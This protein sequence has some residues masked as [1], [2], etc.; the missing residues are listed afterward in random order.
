MQTKLNFIFFLCWLTFLSCNKSNDNILCQEV[1]EI[2]QFGNVNPDSALVLLQ[3]LQEPVYNSNEHTRNTF[4]LAKIRLDDKAFNVPVSD[5]AI[6]KVL[7][8]FDKNG[9]CE[10]KQEAYYYAGSVYRDL[11]DVPRA[12]EYFLKSLEWSEHCQRADSVMLRNSY[13]QLSVL[14]FSVQDYPNALIMA[15]KETEV[16]KK[17]NILDSRTLLHE[18]SIFL[19]L[20]SLSE[21]KRCLTRALEYLENDKNNIDSYTLSSILYQLSSF[22]YK[23]DAYK[24]YQ[25]IIDIQKD[26][27]LP[28]TMYLSLGKYF[29]L[30]EQVDSAI[31]C[32]RIITEITNDLECKYDAFRH[33]SII[34]N[35]RGDNEHANYYAQKFIAVSDSINLGK[36]QT[37]AATI[38]NRFKYQKDKEEEQRIKEEKER[39]YMILLVSSFSFVVIVLVLIS[40]FTYKKNLRLKEFIEKTYELKKVKGENRT[41]QNEILQQENNL[42]IAKDKLRK[43][44]EEL[45]K[46]RENLDL[47]E[48]ELQ[49]AK[50]Q[51]EE[52]LLQSKSILQLLHQTK[53]EGSAE[54]IIEKIR[55]AAD[56]RYKMKELD[57]KRFHNAVNELYP[58]FVDRIL[59]HS[60]KK[61]SDKQLLFCQL[62]RVGI[63]NPQ[64][65]VLLDM[66]KATVWRWANKY[67][68]ILDEDNSTE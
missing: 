38:N 26:H 17:L 10:E 39:Y 21:S 8:Y 4:E 13:S 66:P 6:K 50:N 63:T 24:C 32:Y 29:S 35:S 56:G 5:K 60:K 67:S 52:R 57:W 14:Y 44:D 34:Y 41:L 48:T 23:D 46:M 42:L 12:L 49:L 1:E 51:L 54:D 61:I 31:K 3:E 7:G 15:K 47:S 40:S 33:L 43:K 68:W 25:Y 55:M 59:T 65:Q 18:G 28:A 30:T 53:F 11:N 2:K 16:A 37:E 64:I 58:D 62:I 27:D 20:D 45:R 9:T 19:R 22:G 36:R